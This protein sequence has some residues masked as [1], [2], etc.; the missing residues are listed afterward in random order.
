YNSK[1]RRNKK[2]IDSTL[3][4]NGLDGD[5]TN[6]IKR[7]NAQTAGSSSCDS[8]L[9]LDGGAVLLESIRATDVNQRVIYALVFEFSPF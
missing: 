3:N 7:G 9:D 6:N 1:L 4:E 2:V 5:D 8:D